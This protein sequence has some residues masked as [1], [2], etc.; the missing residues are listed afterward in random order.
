MEIMGRVGG[1]R[2]IF[3]HTELFFFNFKKC[4][5]QILW[6]CIVL[7]H[8]LGARKVTN[9]IKHLLYERG[10]Q[11]VY[12]IIIAVLWNIFTCKQPREAGC[13]C[14][15]WP[16]PVSYPLFSFFKQ[17]DCDT[18]CIEREALHLLLKLAD[19]LWLFNHSGIQKS[20][21][22]N[23]TSEFGR[24]GSRNLHL[25]YEDICPESPQPP[26]E[27]DDRSETIM[28]WRSPNHHRHRGHMYTRK[29]KEMSGQL[30]DALFQLQPSSD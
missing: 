4:T 18:V 20:S 10:S 21:T 25:L 7:C 9:V 27:L 26:C 16:Q 23:V 19:L 1:D 30:P 8:F 11:I 5:I 17:S 28:L 12:L 22:S 15:G 29:D 2:L 3:G 6:K 14:Q 24:K 13:V